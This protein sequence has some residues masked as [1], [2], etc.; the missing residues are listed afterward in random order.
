M[1]VLKGITKTFQQLLALDN[2]NLTVDKGEIVGLIGP[3][4]AG[5]TTLFRILSGVIPAD[6]GTIFINGQDITQNPLQVR[7]DMGVVPETLGL[8]PRLTA[9]EYLSFFGS[10]YG[11]TRQSL[12]ERI[13]RIVELLS[14]EDILDRLCC[15]FSQGQQI[16]LSFA[17]ALLHEPQL[18]ILDEPTRGLDILGTRVVRLMLERARKRGHCILLSSHIMS[19]VALLCDRLII[20]DQGRIVGSGTLKQLQHI[21]DRPDLEEILL[22][23]LAKKHVPDTKPA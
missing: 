23:I 20:I 7:K 1:I 9:R 6:R 4:G 8:Y 10:L 11:L 13:T 17:R 21:A 15:G 12:R 18:L 14:L 2:V 16:R 19:E 5:K 22:Q 3:N